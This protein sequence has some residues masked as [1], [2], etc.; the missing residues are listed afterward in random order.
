MLEPCSGDYSAPENSIEQEIATIW[1]EIL[2]LDRVGRN[3]N[4]FELGGH[5]LLL[6]RVCARIRGELRAEI[7]MTEL[8]RYPTVSSLAGRLSG[9]LELAAA[10]SARGQSRAGARLQSLRRQA[11]DREDIQ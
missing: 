11:A 1:K 8:F 10:A 9:G 5:S 4:F 6:A 7:T 3:E 2:G